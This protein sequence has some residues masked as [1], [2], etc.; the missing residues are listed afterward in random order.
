MP[1]RALPD[2]CCSESP[3]PW[4]SSIGIGGRHP[5]KSVVAIGRTGWSSSIVTGG[6]D[7]SERLVVID[8]TGWPPSIE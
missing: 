3:Q 4:S 8:W 6:R 5:P 1:I 7:R 2:G